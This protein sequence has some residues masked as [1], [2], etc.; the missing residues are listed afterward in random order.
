MRQKTGKRAEKHFSK[1]FGFFEK[2]A[3]KNH[4]E[5]YNEV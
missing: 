2:K 4:F 5:V 3:C 1:N